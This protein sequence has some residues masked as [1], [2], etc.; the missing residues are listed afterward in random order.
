M[1]KKLF[2]I[3]IFTLVLISST[4]AQNDNENCPPF[5]T[6]STTGIPHVNITD[7]EVVDSN[8][9][10]FLPE[11]VLTKDSLAKLVVYPEIAKRGG[12][13]G[14]VIAKVYIDN[15]GKTTRAK[16]IKGIGAGCDEAVL[17]A[18]INA[19]F[20]PAKITNENIKSEIITKVNFLLYNTIDKPDLIFDEIIY[21]KK[22]L[23]FYRKLRLRKSNQASIYEIINQKIQPHKT[24]VIPE[25]LYT[26]LSDFIISQCFLNYEY[27]YSSSSSPPDIQETIIVKIGPTDKSVSTYGYDGVPIGLW[28][29]SIVIQKIEEEINWEKID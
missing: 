5:Y 4:S 12:I 22:G 15:D 24:G 14:E 6:H 18:L 1:K 10:S 17:E 25:G 28:A 2:T 26:K 16:I 8:K 23:G 11:S 29:I 27:S 20:Y 13:E 21:V 7:I 19:K 9:F 3:T